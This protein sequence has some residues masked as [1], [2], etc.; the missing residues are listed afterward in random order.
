MSGFE[1][2]EL[3]PGV[4]LSPTKE[5]PVTV[6]CWHREHPWRTGNEDVTLYGVA[7]RSVSI[8]RW[9]ENEKAPVR[10]FVVAR[11][12]AFAMPYTCAVEGE[13]GVV[14]QMPKRSAPLAFVGP[15]DGPPVKWLGGSVAFY[16]LPPTT[17]GEPMMVHLHVPP[18]AKI[19]PHRGRN[20]QYGVV[21]NGHGQIVVAGEDGERMPYDLTPSM[22]YRLAADTERHF[23][24]NT[25]LDLV[26]WY[27]ESYS[28]WEDERHPLRRDVVT[29]HGKQTSK[30]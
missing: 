27:A 29:S 22:A 13:Q 19:D 11:G 23:V 6:A 15:A 10:Q 30:A 21:L 9:S 8:V 17:R 7:T 26:L 4:M 28:G 12:M 3:N 1:P 5:Q 24:A 2:L 25:P 18:G 16:L 20:D 14:F